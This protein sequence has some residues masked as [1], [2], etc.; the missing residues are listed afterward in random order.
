MTTEFK[1]GIVVFIG[2]SLLFYMSLKV[3][4]FGFLT[5]S[6]YTVVVQFK[7]AAGLDTQAPVQVAGVEVGRVST[8]TLEGNK[9]RVG[10]LMK[11]NVTVPIDSS[12]SIKSLGILGD[13][14]VE[15]ILGN[16]A[17]YAR[18]GDEL[19]NVIS[20]AGYD[21]I[22]QNVSSAAK[23]FSETMEQFKGILG[24][25]EKQNLKT[26][27]ANIASASGEFKEILAENKGNVKQAVTNIASA[28]GN[29]SSLAAKAD[30]AL[31]EINAVVKDVNQGRGTLGKLV[32][33]DT[34]YNDAKDMVASLKSVSTDIEQGKGTLGKLVKDEAIY[35]DVKETVSSLKGFAGGLKDGNLVGEAKVT[36]KKIQEA[37]EGIQEQTPITILG[38]IFGLV[39]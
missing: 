31:V 6:G 13:K 28:S 37:A 12:V 35:A 39:F 38:T 26:G 25:Q 15:I 20:Y 9:A 27:L 33:D 21:E 14:Y 1:V 7:N 23:S 2:I 22:F 36:M 18:D 32:K 4:K 17:T 19:K 29:I 34:L 30:S 8:I 24:E 16:S 11:A 10:L 5:E 3:G